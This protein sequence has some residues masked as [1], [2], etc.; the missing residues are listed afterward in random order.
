[1]KINKTVSQKVLDANRKN[2]KRGPGPASAIGKAAVRYNAV[3][4]GLLAKHIVFRKE[5]EEVEFQVL[6][7][8]LEQEF[9]PE[10]VLE[11]MLV[12]EIAVCWWK[13][14]IALGWELQEIRN[15]RKASK[16]VIRSLVRQSGETQVQLFQD[17]DGS[18][19]AARLNW[20]CNE[21][22]VKSSSRE[23]KKEE[24]DNILGGKEEKAG[25]MEIEARLSNSLETI[26]RYETGLKC[27]LYKAIQV[28]KDLQASRSTA[29]ARI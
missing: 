21:L 23:N 15:R 28:L 1:M 22:I 2:A 8:E 3:K 7:D 12:E 10:G 27:D 6:V 13:L 17:E 14:Q 29:P 20:D 5:E 18:S 4:H 11:R 9:Q 19:P 16:S 24:E 25:R 26:L